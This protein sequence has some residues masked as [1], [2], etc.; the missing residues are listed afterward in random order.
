MCTDERIHHIEDVSF[1]QTNIQSNTKLN[2]N[3]NKIFL[4]RSKRG[5][6]GIRQTDSTREQ[7]TQATVW[8]W[9]NIR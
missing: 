9:C 5:W 6:V 3:A 8:H 4:G 7:N 1:P 2:K